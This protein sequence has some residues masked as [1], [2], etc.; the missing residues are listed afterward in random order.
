MKYIKRLSVIFM[1]FGSFPLAQ[2]QYSQLFLL[3]DFTQGIVLMNDGSKTVSIMN[4]DAGGQV[5]VFLHEDEL[6]MLDNISK[7]DTVYLG[8]RKFIPERNH[9]LEVVPV[10]NGIV[11]INWHYKEINQGKKG[12]YGATQGTVESI[13]TNTYRRGGKFEHNPIDL[14]KV[15]LQNEYSLSLDNKIIKFKDKKGLLKQ[16]KEQSPQIEAYIDKENLKFDKPDDMI[17]LAD[18]CMGLD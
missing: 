7:V 11:Y 2:A 14:T 16:L 12:A 17:E 13:N 9:Y 10:D 5:M 8:K 1:M 3:D 15:K 18:Y 6:F 4:Y